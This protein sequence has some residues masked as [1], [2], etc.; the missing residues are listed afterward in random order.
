MTPLQDR[1]FA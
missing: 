1:N